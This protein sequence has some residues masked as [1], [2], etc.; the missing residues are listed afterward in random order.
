MRLFR[1][2]VL[3]A[4]AAFTPPR[5]RTEVGASMHQRRHGSH[6]AFGLIALAALFAP[7]CAEEPSDDG[8][9]A[10]AAT[11]DV[12]LTEADETDA[13][14]VLAPAPLDTTD[15]ELVDVRGV[16]DSAFSKTH[17]RE[18][19]EAGFGAAL[20][21]FD[22]AGTI[23]RGDLSFIN[24][25]S[26]IAERCDRF[27]KPY[28]A[29]SS[30]AFVSRPQ[31]LTQAHAHGFNLIGLSN[32]HTRDCTG[33]AGEATSPRATVASLE[34]LGE[35]DWLWAGA[36]ATEGEKR[37]AKVHSF[38]IK[39]R[40]VRV[41]FASVYTGRGSCPLAT[42]Q[43]DAR[44]VMESLRDADADLRILAL[45]SQ[46]SQ[47]TLVRTGL[48]F[49]Q[50]YGGD[51]VF[52]HGPHVWKPVRVVRKPSGKRG[53]FFESLGNFLHPGCAAQNRNFVGR[54][55][56]DARLELRQVQVIPVANAG[57]D[58]HLSSVDPTSVEANLRWT[59][60][61]AIYGAY[62]NVKRGP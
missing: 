13:S 43:D 14:D 7:A 15:T 62:A 42:C 24:W 46:D 34:A 31:N 3:R 28:V 29:G 49:I 47:P 33:P 25:E 44:A 60:A 61:S 17:E 35:T 36:S 41:A 22:P 37:T 21:R 45:H 48:D 20:D 59:R 55:L 2:T 26:V 19:M 39:G 16:G 52:G 53:V 30:Y 57:R 56:F 23:L 27:S 6:L 11:T 9:L 38:A 8:E 40:S 54:A 51:V 58:V 50:K 1:L 12:P 5:S 4:L 32:N 10:G 18:P